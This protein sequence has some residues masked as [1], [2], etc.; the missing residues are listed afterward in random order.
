MISWYLGKIV[1]TVGRCVKDGQ[2]L[3]LGTGVQGIVKMNVATV[4][5]LAGDARRIQDMWPH[6]E[7]EHKLTPVT[8]S[9]M[10]EIVS[11]R[12]WSYISG[13]CPDASVSYTS[14]GYE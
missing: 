3:P 1:R 11:A 5:R 9:E 4:G 6:L 12:A 14:T 10:V 13:W 7:K 2:D 8:K